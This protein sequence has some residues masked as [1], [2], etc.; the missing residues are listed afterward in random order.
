[1]INILEA[2]LEEVIEYINNISEEAL[3]KLLKDSTVEEHDKLV[4]ALLEDLVMED[5]M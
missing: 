3:D 1:M 4:K 2:T 5:I